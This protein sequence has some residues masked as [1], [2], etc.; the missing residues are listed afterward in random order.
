MSKE[1]A[2]KWYKQALHDLQM[3]EKNI[4]IQGYDVAAFLA[5]Q[6]VEKLMKSTFAYQG[7]R[8]PKTHYIDE[9]ARELEL[10]EDTIDEVLDLTV[11]YTFARYPD[12]SQHIPYEEYNEEIAKDKVTR[13]RK[14]FHEVKKKCR[15]LKDIE[16]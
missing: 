6:S 11:D 13:A 1:I 14:I 7:K 9:L 4:S 3:A 15:E 2:L 8:I 10:G 12:V 5:H 16:S